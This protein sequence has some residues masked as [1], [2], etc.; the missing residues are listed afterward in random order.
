MLVACSPTA[1]CKFQVTITNKGPGAYTGP[2]NVKDTMPA[3]W[4]FVFRERHPGH[5]NSKATLSPAPIRRRR[6]RPASPSRSTSN[7]S[8]SRRRAGSRQRSRTAQRSTGRARR[9]RATRP[10]TVA[11][12]SSRSA[13]RRRICRSINP[14]RANAFGMRPAPSQ[15]RSPMLGRANIRDRY[16]SKSHTNSFPVSRSR[17]SHRRLPGTAQTHSL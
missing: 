12:R 14:A 6:L 17:T 3:G 7:C 9:R 1:T 10:T 5:A 16:P 13:L 11:A 8:L 4:K 2:L 15:S